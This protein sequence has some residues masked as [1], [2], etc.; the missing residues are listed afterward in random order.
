MTLLVALPSLARRSAAAVAAGALSLRSRWRRARPERADRP[1][2]RDRGAGPRLCA[3]DPQAAGLSKSGINIILVNDRRFNA[4][5]DGR[6]IFIN[7]GALMTAETP[8]EIIGVLAHEAGHLAGGHQQRLRDQLARAQT[9]A[10]VA[11]LLGVGAI[12]AGAA[13]DS[14]AL[15]QS[16]MG[17]A[18]GGGEAARRSL[19]GYQRTEEVTADRSAVTYLEKTGQS[20]KGMLKTF[21][22]F[23]SALSLSGTQVDPYQV[24]HPMPHERIANLEALATAS[25]YFDAVDPPALQLRHDMMRAKIAAFTQGQARRC[26]GC[27]ARI[28]SDGGRLWRCHL[29][30]SAR[31][32]EIGTG[33]DRCADQ[34]TAEEPLFP[35]IARR[36][37]DEEQ[38]AEGCGRGLCQGGQPRSGQIRPAAGLATDRR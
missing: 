37:P 3:A 32:S 30:L 7:T 14:S 29:H 25:P 24:S 27:S 35:R 38:Q 33:Q 9:M 16:G 15:A 28:R 4:F 10:I 22:R 1:R 2:R 12:A 17:I 8:N 11:S 23:Q 36:H 19:L 26:R 13:T 18:V 34:G 5:V 20:A 21:Q 31:Q 6:R